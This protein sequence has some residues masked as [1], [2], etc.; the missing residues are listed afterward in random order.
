VAG[1]AG[2]LRVNIGGVEIPALVVLPMFG[3]QFMFQA[4][5]ILPPLAPGLQV[6]LTVALDGGSPSNPVFIA[7]R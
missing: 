1:S 3:Q 6:P 5:I 7:I 4:Q 2:R